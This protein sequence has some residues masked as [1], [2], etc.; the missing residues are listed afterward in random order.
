MED[1]LFYTQFIPLNA[2]NLNLILR[3]HD[4]RHPLNMWT[5][6]PLLIQSVTQ[7]KPAGYFN[8]HW[9]PCCLWECPSGEFPLYNIMML[10]WTYL[11]IKMLTQHPSALNWQPSP[12]WCSPAGIHSLIEELHLTQ[13][14]QDTHKQLSKNCLWKLTGILF[15]IQKSES[16]YFTENSLK[17]I[18][19]FT[20]NGV[21]A[22]L[23]ADLYPCY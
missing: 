16:I 5:T 7:F 1:L 20:E 18:E 4:P 19:N 11:Q 3:K 14:L 23:S 22:V 9:N 2:G 6:G 21:G 8:F 10:E 15:W 17:M 12:V 13:C